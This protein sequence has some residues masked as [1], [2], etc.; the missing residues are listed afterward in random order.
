MM[1]K[2]KS[3]A[4]G[5]T[6]ECGIRNNFPAY[7]QDHWDVKLLYNCSCERQ[8]VLYRGKVTIIARPFDEVMDSEAFGD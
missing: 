2:L 7:A 3:D 1:S 8:Y 5:F 4:N 6:C